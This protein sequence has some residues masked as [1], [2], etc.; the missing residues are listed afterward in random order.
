MVRVGVLDVRGS[1]T[2]YEELPFNV[3]VRDEGIIRDLDALVIPP[4]SQVESRVLERHPWI[5]KEVWEFV[6]RGGLLIGV[7]S[8]LQLISKKINL[9][10]KGV[11]AYVNG[12]GI[13]DITVEPLVITGPVKVR[14]VR[15]TWATRGLLNE[16]LPG[17]HAHT[18]GKLIINNNEEIVGLAFT[19]RF[20]YMNRELE[21][22]SMVVSSKYRVFG[23][24]THGI[25]G[26]D[27]PI[28]RNILNELDF[29]GDPSEL[30]REFHEHDWA[31]GTGNRNSVGIPRVI[32]VAST[33]SNEGKTLI[34]TAVAR[35]LSRMGYEVGVAKLGGDIRDLHPSLYILRKPF[36]PWMSIKLRWDNAELGIL[37]WD[38]AIKALPRVDILLV[39]GVMGLLTGSSRDHGDSVS[40]T[41]GF[42]RR[43]NGDVIMIAS[44][45]LD[46]V[47]GA[48]LRLR[49]YLN[50]LREL[51]VNIRLVI[52]NEAYHGPG[53]D[54]VL[55]E[56]TGYLRSVGINALVINRL[57]INSK[58]E[59]LMDLKDYEEAAVR[60]GDEGLCRA[61]ADSLGI[62]WLPGPGSH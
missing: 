51:N 16:E 54:R 42:I 53:E 52:I 48:V 40:S 43:V 60:I 14:I 33:M 49:A 37:T 26:R 6:E 24:M 8:G 35:C 30:Y 10:V 22:P 50:L 32:V 46:G 27:S 36:K 11:P 47:E 21:T 61:L 59:E 2:Y 23:T 41:L 17:W 19:H 13:L 20:N 62:Q 34:T 5:S 3:R 1:M 15:E 28:V 25:M 58:P 29:H 44:A 9:N 18:Y 56:F 55:G 45:S 7:C 31:V 57:R 38:E 39:E 12:L 4:G